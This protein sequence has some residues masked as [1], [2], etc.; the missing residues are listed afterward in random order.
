MLS[1]DDPLVATL[2]SCIHS[3]DIAGLE[4][5]LAEHPDLAK[6]RFGDTAMSRTALHVATDWP[7]HFPSTTDDQITNACWHACRAGQLT[8]TQTLLAGG[9]DIDW[10]GYDHLTPHQ[11]ALAS[12]N[13]DLISWIESLSR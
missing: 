4:T 13:D 2:T 10:L 5:L 1:G 7:G 3:G 9:A 11:A 12:G 6:E 8:A